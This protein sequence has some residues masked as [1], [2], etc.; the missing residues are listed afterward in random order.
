M[1][2]SAITRPAPRG[3]ARA[4]PGPAE[5]DVRYIDVQARRSYDNGMQ[6]GE[7]AAEA[8]PAG[9]AINRV[10]LMRIIGF[11]SAAR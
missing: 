2:L 8:F 10:A 5:A 1:R 6:A 9:K 3:A 11:R 7:S 4:E